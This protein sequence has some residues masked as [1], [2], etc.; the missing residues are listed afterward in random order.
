MGQPFHATS[1]IFQNDFYTK[2]HRS[3]PNLQLQRNR[4]TTRTTSSKPLPRQ[5]SPPPM[6]PEWSKGLWEQRKRELA[7]ERRRRQAGR[8]C[9]CRAHAQASRDPFSEPPQPRVP[10]HGTHNAHVPP[11]AAALEVC[12]YRAGEDHR[13]PWRPWR[14][15]IFPNWSAK[16][17][18]PEV[19][20]GSLIRPCCRT[21][22]P[23]RHQS[24]AS[25]APRVWS[26]VHPRRTCRGVPRQALPGVPAALQG[27]AGMV[28]GGIGALPS[29]PMAPWPPAPVRR[30][31]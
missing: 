5:P 12:S 1:S 21:R 24:P 26:H 30:I 11:E 8:P 13:A 2:E 14:C 18:A 6:P 27:L 20:S 3:R 15:P 22:S 31:H 19:G 4:L 7:E 10:E 25:T 29:L 9:A 16:F 23:S 17:Q 28:T